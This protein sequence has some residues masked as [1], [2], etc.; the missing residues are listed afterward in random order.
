MKTHTEND[1][2]E[3]CQIVMTCPAA[4]NHQKR[5]SKPQSAH[6][7][8][9]MCCSKSVHDVNKKQS[10]KKTTSDTLPHKTAVPVAQDVKVTLANGGS[11]DDISVDIPRA[12]VKS[13]PIMS[14]TANATSSTVLL[15]ATNQ[16]VG[17][18]QKQVKGVPRVL[19]AK[20]D[21]S[22]AILSAIHLP[23]YIHTKCILTS[24]SRHI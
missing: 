22:T 24:N 17:H 13:Y 2:R 21:I 7:P 19:S 14:A 23:S 8:S 3:K 15:A 12:T 18:Q 16:P 4:Q 11:S 20:L 9:E 6:K 1:N 5:K 10:V